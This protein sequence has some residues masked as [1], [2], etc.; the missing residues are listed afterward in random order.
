[1]QQNYTFLTT[2]EL[3]NLLPLAIKDAIPSPPSVRKQ[4]ILNAETSFYYRKKNNIFG[5]I[6]LHDKF[7]KVLT[8][9]EVRVV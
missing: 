3:F 2:V 6:S 8:K 1:M 7:K 5:L 9:N 4:D